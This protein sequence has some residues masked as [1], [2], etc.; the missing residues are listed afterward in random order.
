MGFPAP[1]ANVALLTARTEATLAAKK[2]AFFSSFVCLC[3]L[4]FF[5][6]VCIRPPF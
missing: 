3:L 1:V 6:A 4:L 5:F 2:G